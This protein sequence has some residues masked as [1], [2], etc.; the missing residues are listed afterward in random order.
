MCL[1]DASGRPVAQ[2]LSLRVNKPS[3]RRAILVKPEIEHALKEPV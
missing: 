1:A 3:E 2:V